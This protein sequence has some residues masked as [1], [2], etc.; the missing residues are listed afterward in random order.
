MV[1]S[2]LSCKSWLM[3]R[4]EEQ[5]SHLLNAMQCMGMNHNAGPQPEV[6]IKFGEKEMTVHATLLAALSSS[7]RTYLH[8]CKY[9]DTRI[10][11]HILLDFQASPELISSVKSLMYCGSA[12]S[13]AQLSEQIVTVARALKLDFIELMYSCFNN[14]IYTVCWKGYLE[15]LIRTFQ[16]MCTNQLCTD[17]SVLVDGH[18]IKAH[19]LILSACSSVLRDTFQENDNIRIMHMPNIGLTNAQGLIAYM[20]YGEASLMECHLMAFYKLCSLLEV[21]SLVEATKNYVQQESVKNNTAQNEYLKLQSNMKSP[22]KSIWNRL[23][24]LYNGGEKADVTFLVE[25]KRILAHKALLC[26]ASP[27]IHN[28]VVQEP[29]LDH[30]LILVTDMDHRSLRGLLD[31][32]YYGSCTVKCGYGA[33]VSSYLDKCMFIIEPYEHETLEDYVANHSLNRE[34]PKPL[35]T[36]LKH[37][38]KEKTKIPDL[39][40]INVPINNMAKVSAGKADVIAEK[41]SS[42]TD[43]R[44]S[45]SEALQSIRF[46]KEDNI[47]EHY[48]TLPEQNNPKAAYMTGMKLS[49]E[50][51]DASGV[52]SFSEKMETGVHLRTD[53]RTNSPKC[54]LAFSTFSLIK[55]QASTFERSEKLQNPL[56]KDTSSSG[57]TAAVAGK[58]IKKS[59]QKIKLYSCTNCLKIFSSQILLNLHFCHEASIKNLPKSCGLGEKTFERIDDLGDHVNTHSGNDHNKNEDCSKSV[60]QEE[61]IYKKKKIPVLFCEFCGK[62]CSPRGM[63]IHV[64]THLKESKC[65]HCIKSFLLEDDLDHRIKVKHSRVVQDYKCS[66]FSDS[67]TLEA[68]NCNLKM[69]ALSY[70][71]SISCPDCG[72]MFQDI[73]SL[74]S[75]AAEQNHASV[76]NS[77]WICGLCGSAFLEENQ[78]TEHMMTHELHSGGQLIP[79]DF[80]RYNSGQNVVISGKH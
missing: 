22:A 39:N 74:S 42:W 5:S 76:K 44:T 70:N 28:V 8:T 38:S 20:Y 43:I 6:H 56:T 79:P 31:V 46:Q 72:R 26:A 69:N 61:M 16:F 57:T 75:H 23:C 50:N 40:D 24:Q 78:L 71:K 77:C 14:K 19:K 65:P 60:L 11:H 9:Q 55:K 21:E 1:D 58:Q 80:F 64:K 35:V 63:L 18:V 52:P 53:L 41:S 15:R 51:C 66:Q 10:I 12:S 3:V 25:K 59:L 37:K 68:A 49:T 36:S 33:V 27:V 29:T 45:H 17:V 32:I 30:S 47:E 54:N 34:K 67:E 2:V 7:W 4:W 73:A 48:Y 62:P 13:G